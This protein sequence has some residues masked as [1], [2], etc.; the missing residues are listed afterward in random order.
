[1]SSITC[2]AYASVDEECTVGSASSLSDALHFITPRGAKFSLNFGKS[3]FDGQFGSSGS[4]SAFQV[5]EVAKE[6]IESMHRGEILVA[7]AEVIFAKLS[8]GIAKRL[9]HLRNGRILGLQTCD[10]C[11]WNSDFTKTRVAI[12]TLSC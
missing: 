10:R 6:L 3:F 12:D 11:A 4:S 7:V 1:M 5:I 9:Q 8:G 2:F